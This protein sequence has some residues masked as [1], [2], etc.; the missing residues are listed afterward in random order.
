MGRRAGSLGV[1][2]TERAQAWQQWRAGRSQEQIAKALSRDR[3]TVAAI[4][5]RH[6]GYVPAPRR[7]AEDRLTAADR[8]EIS[9]GLSSG[10]SARCIAPRIG[11]HHSTVSREIKR[12]GGR[13]GYRA[14][15]AEKVAWERAQR[16]KP[17]L[18]SLR[19][20]LCSY[21]RR[22]LQRHW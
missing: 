10:L 19:P 8:E 3:H 6:G 21:V 5:G 13:L 9:R 17:C 2:A 7:R 12:N 22:G 14:T 4:I 20:R 16:P 18:L 1:N 11:K 15:L